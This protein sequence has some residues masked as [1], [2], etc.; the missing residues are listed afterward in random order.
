MKTHD[1]IF[2]ALLAVV[3]LLSLLCTGGSTEIG[4]A[5]AMVTGSITDNGR[6][7][8]SAQVQLVAE[9]YI[10]GKAAAGKVFSTLTGC[11]GNY[12][13]ENVPL[14]TYYLNAKGYGKMLLRGPIEIERSEEDLATDALKETSRLTM[15][16]PANSTV[17]VVFL[18][19]TTLSWSIE[20]DTAILDSVPPGAITVVA[21]TQSGAVPEHLT[22]ENSLQIKVDLQP[23][24]AAVA[25]LD[26][27]PPR[28]LST[29]ADLDQVVR[30]IDTVNIFTVRA[31]DP[32]GAALHFSLVSGPAGMSIDSSNGVVRWTAGNS[33]PGGVYTAEVRVSDENGASRTVQVTVRVV[34]RT[35]QISLASSGSFETGTTG[36][37]YLFQVSA[38]F[39]DTVN[40]Y[41]FSW[42]DGDTTGWQAASEAV[43]SWKSPGSFAVRFQMQL[44]TDAS[45]SSWSEPLTMVI[46]HSKDTIPPVLTLLG[47]DTICILD[48][49]SNDVMVRLFRETGYIAI[50]DQD[51]DITER[52]SVSI[53]KG[54]NSIT[55]HYSVQ[56]AS[57]NI[58]RYF[59]RIDIFTH[60]F[61]DVSIDLALPDSIIQIPVSTGRW[62]EPGFTAT[63]LRIGDVTSDVVV[64]SSDLIKNLNNNMP[65]I[66]YVM[67]TLSFSE[68]ENVAIQRI[69]TVQV[70]G[71]SADIIPPVITLNGPVMIYYLDTLSIDIIARTFRE[72]GYTAA[73]DRDG[74]ITSK[75]MAQLD[76][77]PPANHVPSIAYTVSDN[78]GNAADT[79]FRWFFK[80]GESNSTGMIIDLAESD[81]LIRI[82]VS[83]GKW[84]E[85][86][87]TASDSSE[88]DVTSKVVVDSS[89]LVANLKNP[90]VYYVVYSVR[91]GEAMELRKIRA[92]EVFQ[93]AIVESV[94]PVITLMGPN[95]DTVLVGSDTGYFDPG[96]T[97]IDNKDGDIT[98]RIVVTGYV[99]MWIVG[100]YELRYFV[101]DI[102]SNPTTATRTVYVVDSASIGSAPVIILLGDNPDTV[103]LWM[104]PDDTVYHDP[105]VTAYDAQDGDLSSQLVVTGSVNV[106]FPGEY[107]LTY[108]VRDADSNE[109]TATRTVLVS[110]WTNDPDM[111]IKY[112]VPVDT[113]MPTYGPMF[114]Y[115]FSVDGEG[116]DLSTLTSMEL[117]WPESTSDTILHF[118]VNGDLS[119]PTNDNPIAAH[120]FNTNEP[121]ML[122]RDSKIPGMD[123][124]YYVRA[125]GTTM[126][127]VAFSG[128]YAI[129]WKD[130][131]TEFPDWTS[132]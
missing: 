3:P 101:T 128:K 75:V 8:D 76:T 100:K 12:R 109:T 126:Y 51:G 64:D 62:V 83:S 32:E 86:G 113:P 24:E 9:D 2:R 119:T 6:E 29:A 96:A 131:T 73:D 10:P 98:D 120:T 67:Y 117:W 82:P 105:G 20:S 34:E 43:H 22:P 125:E 65:G 50:D 23:A 18:Q 33:L 94:P 39:P 42:G 25:A 44:E 31:T 114:F 53:E 124:P 47:P 74:D 26:N 77:L 19:G 108:F 7:V 93:D 15:G 5:R 121:A 106:N 123:G 30:R 21:F 80:A 70:V 56:D 37:P 52:V 104:S 55:V 60:S 81:T 40:A 90:G 36:R 103:S 130:G 54:W 16:I 1:T 84:I 97:A 57:G 110:T 87:Y 48:S 111:L 61:S 78:A 92:V 41:R 11:H 129:T 127:W 27:A 59:R 89:D 107:T 88:G 63:D 115:S 4:N 46:A 132:P 116:P 112:Q 95:P 72:P 66:Y 35:F 45:I 85:P 79:V 71:D 122:V 14:G 118:H 69:R 13:F 17:N 99:K 68:A 91:K 28:I 38:P 49:I 58:G 102:D